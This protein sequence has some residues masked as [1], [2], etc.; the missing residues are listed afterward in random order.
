VDKEATDRYYISAV[1]DSL[2][3]YA[4][5]F[6]GSMLLASITMLLNNIVR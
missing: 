5:N 1:D 4:T 6:L 3:D 2:E